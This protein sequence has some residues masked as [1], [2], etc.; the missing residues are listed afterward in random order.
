MLPFALVSTS[1]KACRQL[2]KGTLRAV[3][4]IAVLRKCI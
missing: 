2:L 4:R 1:A 3:R